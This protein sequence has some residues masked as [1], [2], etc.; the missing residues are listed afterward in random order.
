MTWSV[1]N[2]SAEANI[3]QL[4][5]TQ[6][7]EAVIPTYNWSAMFAGHLCKLKNIKKYVPSLLNL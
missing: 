7:G 2:E 3:A 6:S 4:I 1:V 5:K